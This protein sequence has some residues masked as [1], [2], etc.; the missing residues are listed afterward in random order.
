MKPEQLALA[1]HLDQIV[2]NVG[3]VKGE[4]DDHHRVESKRARAVMI[5]PGYRL[6]APSEW[7]LGAVTEYCAAV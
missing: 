5:T 6:H 1:A 7:R 2:R 3:K 4:S